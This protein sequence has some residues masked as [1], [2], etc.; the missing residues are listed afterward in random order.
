VPKKMVVPT[1][2]SENRSALFAILGEHIGY[3]LAT[4]WVS[5]QSI[6]YCSFLAYYDHPQT[7]PECEVGREETLYGAF[8]S[9]IFFR[10]SQFD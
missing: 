6:M 1:P 10:V 4:S 5:T 2:F 7:G 8:Y 9:R 3:F